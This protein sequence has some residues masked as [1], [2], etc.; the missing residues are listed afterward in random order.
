[1][2][3]CCTDYDVPEFFQSTWH[4]AR[5]EHRC[6]E[7]RQ[8]ITVG[9]RYERIAGKWEGQFDTFSTCEKCAD[10]RDSLNDVT[11]PAIG[12]LVETYTEYL[13]EIGASRYNE[14]ADRYVWPENHLR[15]ND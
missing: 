7:C 2:G 4:T 15:L 6:C 9:Q 14:D 1:M 13:I 12:N 10:L 5:K 11:C 3:M 8:P